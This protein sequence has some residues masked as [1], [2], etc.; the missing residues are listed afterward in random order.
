MQLC[1]LKPEGFRSRDEMV[2]K[3][4]WEKMQ[5]CSPLVPLIS[6]SEK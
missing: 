4:K 1:D 3:Q 6:T 2:S 5:A